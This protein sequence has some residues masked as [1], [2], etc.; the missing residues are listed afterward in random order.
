M[1]EEAWIDRET[2]KLIGEYGVVP[3]PWVLFPTTH[4]YSI[5]W[6]MGGGESFI[7]L[8]WQWW[9]RQAWD[10]AQCIEYFRHWPPPPRWFKWTIDA[11]WNTRAED[12]EIDYAPYFDRIARL[13]FGTQAE[14][15]QDMDDP[16]WE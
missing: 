4:P 10:E 12:E 3:P 1:S 6:R 14:Y 7:A 8:F 9:Q 5:C 16:R 15:E 11:I 2:T 13:G